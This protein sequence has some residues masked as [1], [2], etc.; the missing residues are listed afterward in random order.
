MVIKRNL[1]VLL[2]FIITNILN[3]IVNNLLIS[4]HIEPKYI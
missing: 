1:I 2:N 4:M 3:K